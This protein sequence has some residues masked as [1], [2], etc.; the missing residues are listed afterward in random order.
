MKMCQQQLQGAKE[1]LKEAKQKRGMKM[2]FIDRPLKCNE[3]GHYK[4]PDCGRTFTA[5]GYAMHKKKR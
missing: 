5:D 4:C 2:T 3:K 1:L